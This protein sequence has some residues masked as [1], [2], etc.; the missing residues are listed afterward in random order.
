MDLRLT[1]LL[2]IQKTVK[3]K[4]STTE[5]FKFIKLE[6]NLVAVAKD[7]FFGSQLF[8]GLLFFLS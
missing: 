4:I 5:Q 2:R 6:T 8:Y 7:D 3:N 1:P